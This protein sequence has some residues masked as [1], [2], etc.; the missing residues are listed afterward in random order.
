MNE[1]WVNGYYVLTFGGGVYTS[2]AWF[3]YKIQAEKERDRIISSGGW[4]GMPPKI[5]PSY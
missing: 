2:I 1:R 3:K 4:S 5:E